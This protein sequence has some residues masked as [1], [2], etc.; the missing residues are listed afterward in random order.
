MTQATL[1]GAR[2]NRAYRRIWETPNE[3]PRHLL[4]KSRPRRRY[5]GAGFY[6]P[7]DARPDALAGRIARQARHPRLFSRRLEPGVRGPDGALQRGSA[8]I[9]EIRR[10]LAGHF[11]G[12]PVVSPRL[13]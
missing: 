7:R 9:S 8:G 5:R 1:T 4:H 13:Y 11:G 12:W 6:T 2:T 3:Y 10:C